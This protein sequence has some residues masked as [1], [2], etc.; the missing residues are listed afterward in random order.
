MKYDEIVAYGLI[1]DHGSGGTKRR[2]ADDSLGYDAVQKPG[3]CGPYAISLRAAGR[4][5]AR[6]PF[7]A[8]GDLTGYADAAGPRH[9]PRGQA[10]I[11]G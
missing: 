4:C 9:H 5:A 8:A 10:D 11:C 7:R 1:A 3:G 6:V 2:H